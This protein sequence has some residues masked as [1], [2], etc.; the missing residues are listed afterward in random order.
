L[1]QTPPIFPRSSLSYPA[2]AFP[3]A[4]SDLFTAENE[5]EWSF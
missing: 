4:S 1:I 5:N 3:I 2:S